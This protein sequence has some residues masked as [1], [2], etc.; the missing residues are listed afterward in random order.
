M[1]INP[2]GVLIAGDGGA[3]AGAG[4][5]G[6][7]GGSV[8]TASVRNDGD[9]TLRAGSGGSGQN[10]VGAIVGGASGSGGSIISSGLVSQFGFGD[11]EAGS[12][13]M[14]GAAAGYGGSIQG[15]TSV[16]AADEIDGVRAAT[17]ITIKSGSGAHGGSGGNISAVAFEGADGFTAPTGAVADPGWQRLFRRRHGRPRRQYF[18]CYRLRF[19]RAKV[20]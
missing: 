19:F 6:G 4:G 18:E 13:G 9:S 17:S 1:T 16:T 12:A 14:G 3:G 11:L 8:L 7:S 2:T 15:A 5:T 20:S 10:T